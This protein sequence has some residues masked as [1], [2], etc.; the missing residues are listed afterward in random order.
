[1]PAAPPA[2]DQSADSAPPFGSSPATGPVPNRGFEA[3]GLQQ[4]GVVIKQLEGMI[5]SLGAASPA[6]KDVLKALSI[7]TKHVPPGSVSPAAQKNS[8]EQAMLKAASQNQQMQALKASQ[9]GGAG[10]PPAQQKV[11]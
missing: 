10:A 1:M 6:G 7:L 3:A 8:L 11:A 9:A 5:A 2:P 4:L